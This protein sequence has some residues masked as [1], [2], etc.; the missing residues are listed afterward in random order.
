MFELEAK[1]INIPTEHTIEEPAYEHVEYIAESLQKRRLREIRRHQTKE[2]QVN[3]SEFIRMADKECQHT[4]HQM[5]FASQTYVKFNDW[6]SQTYPSPNDDAQLQT[7]TCF[8][9]D[10][11]VQFDGFKEDKMIQTIAKGPI[12]KAKMKDSASQTIQ[13][14]LGD[15]VMLFAELRAEAHEERASMVVKTVSSDAA[16]LRIKRRTKRKMKKENVETQTDREEKASQLMQ[17]ELICQDEDEKTEKVLA[18]WAHETAAYSMRMAKQGRSEFSWMDF[19]DWKWSPGSS[20]LARHRRTPQLD[21]SVQTEG[22][23]SRVIGR[24][25]A[26]QEERST[27]TDINLDVL[28]SIT[29]TLKTEQAKPRVEDTKP[30]VSVKEQSTQT[31]PD[32]L[33]EVVPKRLSSK[34]KRQTKEAG[35]QTSASTTVPAPA[36][37]QFSRNMPLLIA[38]E[39]ATQTLDERRWMRDEANQTD[40]WFICYTYKLTYSHY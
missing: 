20:R 7:D 17:A 21:K 4:V 36:L 14:I 39:E 9:E 33:K 16:R 2:T 26:N 31:D 12:R 24:R 8:H 6:W 35:S 23:T 38:R 3:I 22:W 10:K 28:E 11:Q 34:K 30:I 15:Q 18:C 1:S 19:T 29:E 13:P 5:P 27:Q 25:P 32:Q 40:P 37:R